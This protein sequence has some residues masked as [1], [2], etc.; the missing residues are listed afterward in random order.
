MMETAKRYGNLALLVPAAVLSGFLSTPASAEAE[1]RPLG[2]AITQ[3]AVVEAGELP[4]V[5]PASFAA[6]GGGQCGDV[7]CQVCCEQCA[8]SGWYLSASGGWQHRET[9]HEAND[10]QTF[11]TF[12]DGFSANAALGYRFDRFRIEAETSFMNNEVDRAGAGGNS[13]DAA[14]NVNIRALMFNI[15]H[16]IDLNIFRWQPYVGAGI[17]LYQSDINSLYP[18]FFDLAGAP[19]AGTA[20][21]S[22]SDMPFAYQFR[23]GLTRQLSEKS[24]FYTGYRYFRGEELEFAALPFSNFA[25]TFHPEGV[26]SHSVEFGFRINF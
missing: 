8:R 14:G 22:T 17:G 23:A 12:D 15:Y 20:V 24:E 21:N 13:S 11:L 2:G 7:G 18:E 26:K 25:P 10:P 3:V 4:S 5:V 1:E 19:M 6:C 9:V 16:D